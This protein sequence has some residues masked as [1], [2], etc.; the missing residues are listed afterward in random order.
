MDIGSLESP[1]G[2]QNRNNMP[3]IATYKQVS[4]KYKPRQVEFHPSQ[5]Q[6]LFGT[7][8]GNI[9][10]SN[11][12][13]NSIDYLGNY[14]L[15]PVDPILG[16]CWLKANP[17]RFISGS[18]AGR[19]ICGDVR[20]TTDTCDNAV[21][22]FSHIR[23]YQNFNELTSVHTNCLS[24]LL[25][26]SGYE[27]KAKVFDIETGSM[28]MEYTDIHTK[29]I[30]ISRF[31]NHSPFVLATSSFDGTVKSWDLRQRTKIPIYEIVTD[32]HYVVMINYSHD[33]H[34]VL[35]SGRD[36]EITQYLAFDG[37]K[38]TSFDIPR[39]GK[40]EHNYTRAYYTATGA[41]IITGACEE[42]A[43][44]VLCTATGRLLSRFEIYPDRKHPSVYVQ[45]RVLC[46]VGGYVKCLHVD[47]ATIYVCI[48]QS[49]NQ[50]INQST[51]QSINQ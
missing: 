48:Y 51:N 4:G 24:E 25:L 15:S 41:H 33:D 19:V 26:L 2:C 34:F 35:V 28:L 36:N 1:D 5:E 7:V 8:K 17:Y 12:T 47:I 31:S 16:L 37:R 27:Q 14:G 32:S 9:C 39:T 42:S 40:F 50:S 20:L 29:A 3:P 10:L 49:I 22:T 44:S 30:N 6:L 18:G 23:E 38:H 11:L 13:S 21:E 43:V 45:V 46:C